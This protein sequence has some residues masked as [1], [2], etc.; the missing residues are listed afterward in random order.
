MKVRLE[1]NYRKQYTLEQVDQA[2]AVIQFERENDDF[3][4]I[5][6]AEMAALEAAKRSGVCVTDWM[7]GWIL[8]ADAITARNGRAWDLYGDGTGDMDVWIDA[9]VRTG[10]GFLEV[11]AYLSDIWQTGA[12]DYSQYMYIKR[13]AWVE[14]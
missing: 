6:W 12:T 2:R 1:K 7:D 3:T 11:G 5:Q 14:A 8:K 10:E 13:Y 9:V 4:I